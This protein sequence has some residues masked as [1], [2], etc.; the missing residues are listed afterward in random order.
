MNKTK[1][2]E[3]AIYKIVKIEF[4]DG[5]ILTGWLV[6]SLMCKKDYDLLPLNE[7]EDITTFC[8]SIVK[9]I[10]FLRNGYKIW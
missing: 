6:P 10:Y 3:N 1:L 2:I 9:H 8:V 5:D 7:F 4:D